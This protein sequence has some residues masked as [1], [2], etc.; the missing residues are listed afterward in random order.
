MCSAKSLQS[1]PPLGNPLDYIVQQVP[2][3]MEF[4]R[5]EYCSGLPFPSPGNTHSSKYHSL[6]TQEGRKLLNRKISS[7]PRDQTHVSYVSCTGRQVLYHWSQLG[8]P[9]VNYI[10][11]YLDCSLEANL[12]DIKMFGNPEEFFHLENLVVISFPY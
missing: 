1:C 11:S 8:S 5:Q 6:D 4:S 7:Q 3:C 12:P 10:S 2:P 9:Q